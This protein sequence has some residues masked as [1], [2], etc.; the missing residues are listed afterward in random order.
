[1]TTILCPDAVVPE[2]DGTNTMPADVFRIVWKDEHANRACVL[3]QLI[4]ETPTTYAFATPWRSGETFGVHKGL[5][6]ELVR[7]TAGDFGTAMAVEAC[8]AR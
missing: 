2:G 5:V 6:R 4:S 8:R 1:M 3:G 7:A